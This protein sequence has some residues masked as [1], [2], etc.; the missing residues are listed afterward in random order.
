MQIAQEAQNA[1]IAQAVE[2]DFAIVWIEG[3]DAVIWSAFAGGG[4]HEQI[5]RRR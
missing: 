5:G 4:A 3:D 1:R 2:K